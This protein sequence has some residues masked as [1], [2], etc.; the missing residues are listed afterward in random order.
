MRLLHAGICRGFHRFR[1]KTSQRDARRSAPRTGRQFVSL[2]HL[3]RH[4]A[5]RGG[6]S[7]SERRRLMATVAWPPADK[8]T[9]IGKR[10][11]RL[12]GPAKA[13]GA[14]KYTYDIN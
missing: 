1:K 13:T 6:R 2:R 11:D 3:R 5:G 12:D 10:I 4:D 14:A 7:Q 9:L 8:R